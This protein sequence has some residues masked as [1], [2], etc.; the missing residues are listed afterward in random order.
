MN[1]FNK[2]GRTFQVRVQADSRFRKDAEQIK[3]LQAR[4]NSGGMV[5]LGTIVNVKQTTGPGVI[6]R[7]NLYPSAAITGEPAAGHSSG[8]ALAN[9][10]TTGRQACRP[11]SAT[12][13]PA[14]PI[15]NAG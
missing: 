4:N 12:N 7:Y 14:W 10:G 6:A 2:F 13:G 1:D 5:P 9:D 3:R 8:E 11:P 15:R